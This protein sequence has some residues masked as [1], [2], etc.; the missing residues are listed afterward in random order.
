MIDSETVKHDANRL[1]ESY[2]KTLTDLDA[3]WRRLALEPSPR[4][5]VTL[6]RRAHDLT[7]EARTLAVTHER[8]IMALDKLGS[9][10]SG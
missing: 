1:Q 5:R 10:D 4:R 7:Y 9:D 2:D 6:E 8:A 3:T